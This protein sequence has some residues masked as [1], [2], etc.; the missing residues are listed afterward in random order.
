MSKRLDQKGTS[1]VWAKARVTPEERDGMNG[2]AQYLGE[3][4]SQMFRRLYAQERARLVA[5]GK[6]PP[7][8]PRE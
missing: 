4:L 1:T 3:T 5:E 6:R 8:R 7:L 2:L